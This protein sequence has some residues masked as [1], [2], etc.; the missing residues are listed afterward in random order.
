MEL[1][2][3]GVHLNPETVRLVFAVVGADFGLVVVLR[4]GRILDTVDA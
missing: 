1:S 4:A 2:S 3:D